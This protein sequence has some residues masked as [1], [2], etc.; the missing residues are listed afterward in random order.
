MSTKGTP[1]A[2]RPGLSSTPVAP[3]PVPAPPLPPLQ[4]GLPAVQYRIEPPSEADLKPLC[5]W[6][7]C[8]R[9]FDRAA[10]LS[11]H[12]TTEHIQREFAVPGMAPM[13]IRCLWTNCDDVLRQR[14]SLVTHVQDLH[15]ND[16][17][18]RLA[19]FRRYELTK[20][21]QTNISAPRPPPPHP[22]YAPDAPIIAIRR[23]ALNF[24]PKEITD[25]SEG[26]VTKSLRLTAA[27]TLRNLARYNGT[28]RG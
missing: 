3:S 23:H 11:F 1:V 22:G 12:V 26:P 9:I 20:C 17:I 19:A 27:L 2:K 25:E 21:G 6:G 4:Q 24:L 7:G 5:E 13:G 10:D 14:W 16:K 18:V 15:C 8:G 28:A